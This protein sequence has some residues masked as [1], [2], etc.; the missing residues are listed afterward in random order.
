MVGWS[1][2]IGFRPSP[3]RLPS[4]E[5]ALGEGDS[6]SM[7]FSVSGANA[8]AAARIDRTLF[9]VWGADSDVSAPTPPASG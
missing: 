4:R 2:T 7:D 3:E 9:S 8:P 6:T 1:R 5:Q